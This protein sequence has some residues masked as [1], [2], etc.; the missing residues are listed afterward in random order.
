[1]D[2]AALDALSA[3]VTDIW[4]LP[5]VPVLDKPTPTDFLRRAVLPHHPVIIR[6]LLDGWPAV[7]DPQPWTLASVCAK[8]RASEGV[9]VTLTPDGRA[10]APRA[11]RGSEPPHEQQHR[12]MYP[13]ECSMP[14]ALFQEML[15]H[16]QPGDAVPYL[17]LQNDNLRT[18]YPELLADIRP[19]PLAAEAFGEATAAAPEA[20]NLWVGD[21]RSVSSLHKGTTPHPYCAAKKTNADTLSPLQTILIIY[22]VLFWV[23]PRRS[24]YYRRQTWPFSQNQS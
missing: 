12:F 2:E 21:E 13:C 5:T 11:L 24:R 3:D 7:S 14:A 16:P 6:G 20:V 9:T 18:T 19:L 8:V 17:S 23:A 1:M 15:E 22:I 10:D 4:V